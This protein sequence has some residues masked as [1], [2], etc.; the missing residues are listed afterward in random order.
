VGTRAGPGA[1]RLEIDLPPSAHDGLGELIEQF[2]LYRAEV[3]AGSACTNAYP[4]VVLERRVILSVG[5]ASGS[6]R[7]VPRSGSVA[8]DS[9]SGRGLASRPAS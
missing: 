7:K 4:C 5:F 2:R 6:P 8:S 1:D 3:H 9:A